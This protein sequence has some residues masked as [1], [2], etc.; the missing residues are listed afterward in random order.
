MKINKILI[1][2]ITLFCTYS[3]SAQYKLDVMYSIHDRE[4]ISYESITIPQDSKGNTIT[5][6]PTSGTFSIPITINFDGT[7]IAPKKMDSPKTFRDVVENQVA[8]FRFSEGYSSGDIITIYYSEPSNNPLQRLAFPTTPEPDNLIYF[9]YLTIFGDTP[10]TPTK[11]AITLNATKALLKAYNQPNALPYGKNNRQNIYDFIN[12]G[13]L[14]PFEYLLNSDSQKLLEELVLSNSNPATSQSIELLDEIQRLLLHN[15][16]SRVLR[17]ALQDIDK[18]GYDWQAAVSHRVWGNNPKSLIIPKHKQSWSSLMEFI[19]ETLPSNPEAVVVEE[20]LK[21]FTDRYGGYKY[22][23]FGH[24]ESGRVDWARWIKVSLYYKFEDEFIANFEKYKIVGY[25][26][27]SKEE[28]SEIFGCTMLRANLIA[29][30]NSQTIFEPYILRFMDGSGKFDITVRQESKAAYANNDVSLYNAVFLKDFISALSQNKKVMKL[31]DKKKDSVIDV[32]F[33][34]T[35]ESTVTNIKITT[36]S[37]LT[38]KEA[39]MISEAI[40]KALSSL[41]KWTPAYRD[42]KPA[43]DWMSFKF[44]GNSILQN[45]R[46][47]SNSQTTAEVFSH[48]THSTTTPQIQ[49]ANS[50]SLAGRYIVGSPPVPVYVSDAEGCV[51]VNIMVDVSGN[52]VSATY[53]ERGSTTNDSGLINAAITAARK[54]RFNPTDNKDNQTGTMTYN[55]KLQ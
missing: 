35:R 29:Y 54:A 4:L 5:A 52:V 36:P 24:P 15:Y 51:I 11:E 26:N 20:V 44:S 8:S 3:L 40:T 28:V 37:T 49:R 43:L 18:S 2:L 33:I 22:R 27:D 12:N 10:T 16:N 55:F 45:L 46:S 9:L 17:L 25:P 14:F 30:K 39:A 21:S 13:T 48:D 32:G 31:L 38:P 41:S 6:S 1:L 50:F 19:T 23:E 42:H 47:P 53:S 34:V 7:V